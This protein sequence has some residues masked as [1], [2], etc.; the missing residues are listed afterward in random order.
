MEDKLVDNGFRATKASH[1]FV[2]GN[3]MDEVCIHA[4]KFNSK[5]VVK[6][7]IVQ[8]HGWNEVVCQRHWHLQSCLIYVAMEG[9][10]VICNDSG[11]I[12]GVRW[13]G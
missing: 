4:I 7:D 11:M 10:R 9:H 5:L 12:H 3:G 1:R 6:K 13:Q 2:I 8:H